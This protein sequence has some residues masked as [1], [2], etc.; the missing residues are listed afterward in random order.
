M[1]S[2]DSL[3]FI[4]LSIEFDTTKGFRFTDEKRGRLTEMP[5]QVRGAPR[6]DKRCAALRLLQWRTCYNVG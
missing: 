2:E 1:S 6:Y 3:R 4:A 5:V